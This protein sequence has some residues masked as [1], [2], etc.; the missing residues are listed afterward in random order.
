MGVTALF[1]RGPPLQRF[2]TSTAVERSGVPAAEFEL[3]GFILENDM[4]RDS[5]LGVTDDCSSTNLIISSPSSSNSESCPSSSSSSMSAVSSSVLNRNLSDSA[6]ARKKFNRS[7]SPSRAFRLLG[8]TSV[9]SCRWL[10][11]IGC[12]PSSPMGCCWLLNSCSD[13]SNVC[14]SNF[15][16]P[17]REVSLKRMGSTL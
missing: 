17:G 6:Y 12:W 9:G 3:D 4:D 10:I 2:L 13:L 5:R 11:S 1:R 15:R 8:I 14:R 16:V 7:S